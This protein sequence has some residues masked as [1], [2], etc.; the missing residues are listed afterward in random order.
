MDINQRLTNKILGT[1]ENEDIKEFFIDKCLPTIPDYFWE[2]PASSSGRYHSKIS[3]GK[4][5]LT[6]HTIA[7]IRVLNYMLEVASVADQ[8]TSRERDLMRIAGFMHD[9]RKSGSQQDYEENKSTKFNHPLQAAEVIRGLNGLP[10]EEIELIAHIIESHMGQFNTSKKEPNVVLPTPQDKYQII[11]HLCDY[12]VSRK[13]L[14]LAFDSEDMPEPEP[15]PDINTWRFTFGKKKGM[16]IPEVAA[17]DP[18]Y[19][20]WAKANMEME[21]ARSLLKDFKI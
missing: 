10:K 5:G 4:G 7:L 20:I 21:P 6:R 18:G 13:D 12:I 19:I 8:F 3:L 16:T 2:V 17:S 14:E 15:L 11:V 1:F 9:T